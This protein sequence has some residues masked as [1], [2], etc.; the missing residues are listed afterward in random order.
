MMPREPIVRF[1]ICA[2]LRF[3]KV[4]W[5]VSFPNVLG[6]EAAGQDSVP[7]LGAVASFTYR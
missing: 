6:N 7:P 1:I 2:G 5:A 3:I 4:K